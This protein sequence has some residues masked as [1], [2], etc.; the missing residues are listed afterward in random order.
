MGVFFAGNRLKQ[1][2]GDR[3]GEANS[4]FNMGSTFAKLKRRSEALQ[5][6]QQAQQIYAELQL[7]NDVKDCQTRI[8]SLQKR[9]LW[10]LRS[11]TRF[12]W[13]G[14]FL[15]GVAIVLAIAWWLKK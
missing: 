5:N 2:I 1:E 8:F 10:Y 4:L 11:S 9:P 13:W 6:Y 15:V 12:P 3:R 14:W 7:E